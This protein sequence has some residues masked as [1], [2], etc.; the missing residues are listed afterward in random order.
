MSEINI[1]KTKSYEILQEIVFLIKKVSLEIEDANIL[2]ESIEKNK[3]WVCNNAD[4]FSKKCK[5]QLKL[6]EIECYELN[7][8]INE[9]IKILTNYEEIDKKI[10]KLLDGEIEQ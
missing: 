10:L 3:V 5:N 1:S 4:Y 9:L 8:S 7:K 6:L 2:I